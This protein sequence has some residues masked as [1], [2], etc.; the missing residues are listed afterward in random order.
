MGWVLCFHPNSLEEREEKGRRG[1]PASSSCEEHR[2]RA[3]NQAEETRSPGI[4]SK[5]SLLG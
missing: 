2:N 1:N 5:H 4:L 3:E